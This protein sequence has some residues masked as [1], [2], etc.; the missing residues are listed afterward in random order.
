MLNISCEMWDK[1]IQDQKLIFM[2]DVGEIF[3]QNNLPTY[4]NILVFL[5]NNGLTTGVKALN[6]YEDYSVVKSIEELWEQAL[7]CFRKG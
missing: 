2:Q 3:D 1:L 5:S 7:I 4:K 6:V